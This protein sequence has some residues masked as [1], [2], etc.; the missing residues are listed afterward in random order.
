[1]TDPNLDPGGIG[2]AGVHLR[3]RTL[4]HRSDPRIPHLEEEIAR[5]FPPGTSPDRI[6]W[7]AAVA[8]AWGD[9]R[10]ELET[11]ATR[12]RQA[13]T[14]REPAG[15]SDDQEDDPMPHLPA[16]PAARRSPARRGR[17]KWGGPTPVPQ[18]RWEDRPVR[19]QLAI[20]AVTVIVVLTTMA[21]LLGLIQAAVD[22]FP[23]P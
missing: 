9:A 21:A 19:Q 5:H 6:H 16:R 17:T 1:M 8:I 20:A 13:A 10:A 18:P 12:A 11:R 2:E 7:E 3:A 23:R 4:I 22:A 14:G 15:D